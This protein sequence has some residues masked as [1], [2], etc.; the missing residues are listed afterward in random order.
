VLLWV[1]SSPKTEAHRKPDSAAL[2]EGSQ[3]LHTQSTAEAHTRLLMQAV[4]HCPYFA[5]DRTAASDS[6]HHLLHAVHLLR[7]AAFACVYGLT[8]FGGTPKI[9]GLAVTAALAIAFA[10]AIQFTCKQHDRPSY[11]VP[12]FPYIPA[13]SLLLNSF[14]MASLPARAYWQLGLFFGI[15]VIFYLLYSVHAGNRFDQESASVRAGGVPI[16]SKAVDI[17]GGVPVEGVGPAASKDTAAAPHAPEPLHPPSAGASF[18]RQVSLIE[19]INTAPASPRASVLG[20][21][22]GGVTRLPPPTL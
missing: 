21:R 8:E 20:R 4:Q 22:S 5:T 18:G 17:E 13:A 19:R 12:A 16:G 15:M 11:R 2:A 6:H 14:L 7:V 9:I 3:Q 1:S 10:V